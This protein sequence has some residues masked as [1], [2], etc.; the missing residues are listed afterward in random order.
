MTSAQ[1]AHMNLNP[2]ERPTMLS[3][4]ILYASHT[5]NVNLCCVTGVASPAPLMSASESS[6]DSRP[7]ALRQAQNG[8]AANDVPVSDSEGPS[9]AQTHPHISK[10]TATNTTG[11]SGD[12][13]S[14]DSSSSSSD[15][16]SDEDIPLAARQ[17][18]LTPKK[19][20]GEKRKRDG[21]T[22]KSSE[23]KRQRAS[24]TASRGSSSRGGGAKSTGEKK[25]TTLEHAGVLF[26]PE[27]EP[28]GVK[29]MYDGK[30]VEL[31]PE[32]VG[33]RAVAW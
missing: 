25:W 3:F 26:P 11:N 32:Q 12:D 24:G 1:R 5:S 16:D 9:G 31:T 10:P 23:H 20:V 21:G 8:A 17:K 22:K 13:G 2:T 19:P 15:S 14:E 4:S 29:M 18:K 6:D 7:L 27:Y 28:H 33:I 30:P